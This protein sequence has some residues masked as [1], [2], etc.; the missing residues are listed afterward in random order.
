[1]FLM[2]VL[3]K[4]VMVIFVPGIRRIG[5]IRLLQA[6]VNLVFS[7]IMAFQNLEK[8]KIHKILDSQEMWNMDSFLY[9][10][11]MSKIKIS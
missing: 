6:E 10:S 1:M 9:P 8:N 3:K 4:V 7:K 11:N 2:K 5:N